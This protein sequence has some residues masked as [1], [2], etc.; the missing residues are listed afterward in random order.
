[1][2]LKNLSKQS[3][4]WG[5]YSPHTKLAV[6]AVFQPWRL[7]VDRPGRPPTVKNLTVGAL[8][9]TARSTVPIQRA[10]ALWPV[11]RP[12]DRPSLTVDRSGRPPPPESGVLAV[13]RPPGRPAQVAGQRARFVHVGRPVRST[14]SGSGRPS[15][16]TARAWQK[17]VRDRKTWFKIF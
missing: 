13:G 3:P 14:D 17:A 1:L 10:N 7:A 16:S 4:K 2:P 15:R 11:D 12:V 5:I 9:S 8:R 6:G